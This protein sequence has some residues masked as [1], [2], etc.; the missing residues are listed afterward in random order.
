MD[1]VRNFTR[2]KASI[3]RPTLSCWKIGEP[4]SIRPKI[5]IT[6]KTGNPKTKPP[7]EKIISKMRIT[8][9]NTAL[10]YQQKNPEALI[11]LKMVASGLV[12]L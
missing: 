2:V 10:P 6:S 12:D 4:V 3:L 9:P 1:I 11:L 5:Q 8:T 7:S